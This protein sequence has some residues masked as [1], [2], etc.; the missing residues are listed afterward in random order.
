MVLK[1]AKLREGQNIEQGAISLVRRR[2]PEECKDILLYL[3][4]DENFID[5]KEEGGKDQVKCSV[6]AT[7]GTSKTVEPGQRF[8]VS[9]KDFI[10][11][12]WDDIG[13]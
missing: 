7:E 10:A 6:I 8:T 12:T 3:R 13:F 9:Y 5:S 11:G 2:I 4:A 1:L